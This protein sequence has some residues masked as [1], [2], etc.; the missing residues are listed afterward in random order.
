[1]KTTFPLN[2]AVRKLCSPSST[3]ECVACYYYTNTAYKWMRILQWVI[4]LLK[5]YQFLSFPLPFEKY[6]IN[7]GCLRPTTHKVITYSLFTY[8]LQT[9]RPD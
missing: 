4:Q 2:R 3:L 6:Q 5:D 8:F 7:V 9:Y 1:M